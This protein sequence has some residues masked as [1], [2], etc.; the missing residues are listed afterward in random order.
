MSVRREPREEKYDVIV[1]GSGL[2][3]LSAAACLAK[4]GKSVLVVE[5]HDRPGGYAHA[6]QRYRYHFDSAVHMI[7]GAEPTGHRE[8]GIIDQLLVL[9]GVRDKCKFLRVDPFY[10]AVFPGLRVRVPVGIDEF[11][12]AHV[13]HFP[14]EEE[15]LRQLI[16]ICSRIN[17]ETRRIPDTLS[18]LDILRMPRQYPTLFKYRNATLEKVLNEYLRDLRLKSLFS[19]LWP[20][21]GLPPSRLS[22]VYWSVM[23]MSFV[24]EGAYYCQGTFQNFVNALVEAV[25]A[26]LGE[27]FLS[28]RVRRIDVEDNHAKGVV[29]ENGERIKAP[30]VISNA[31]PIQTFEE[32]VG[33]EKL[34]KRF[35]SRLHRLKSSLSAFVLYLATDLDLAGMGAEHEMFFY[36]SWNHDETF[37]SITEGRPG[38]IAVTVPTM[39]D[40][41]LAPQ[42]QHLITATTLIPYDLGSS[43]RAEK[44]KYVALLMGELETVFPGLRSHVTFAEGG[45]PRTMERYTLNLTGAIYGWELSPEQVGRGRLSHQTPVKGLYLSGHWTQPGGGTY[46]VTVSGVQTAAMILGYSGISELFERMTAQKR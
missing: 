3:G 2:G 29:L 24:E 14:E 6:F 22:F 46:G 41:S 45:S 37:R 27:V 7:G 23:L 38:G 21:L 43:W 33:Q 4:M 12:R 31:D 36:R 42:G 35:I 39:I 32:L 8:S 20:Y 9:L 10:S 28:S 18:L 16:R 15:G 19:S 5:R 13:E 44:E 34:P 25:K 11:V 30:T 1:I 17:S 40:P 26:N